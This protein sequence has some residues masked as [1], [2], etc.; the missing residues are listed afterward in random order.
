MPFNPKPKP[1]KRHKDASFSQ[2]VRERDGVCLYGVDFQDPCSGGLQAHHLEKRSQL[3]DDIP[4][5]GI[6]LCNRHHWQAEQ[7]RIPKQV[8]I[9][10]LEQYYGAGYYRARSD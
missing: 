4:E 8:L 6:S 3:G 10:L 5:N 7:N 9:N 1:R 2:Q